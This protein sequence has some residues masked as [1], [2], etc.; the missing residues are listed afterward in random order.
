M[1][2]AQRIAVSSFGVD[3]R[4]RHLAKPSEVGGATTQH[5]HP[6]TL[7]VGSIQVG[8]RYQRGR[9]LEQLAN[10]TKDDASKVYGENCWRS[11]SERCAYTD[12]FY[13]SKG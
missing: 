7:A 4:L 8:L 1:L 2:K 9:T 6:G 3:K 13:C 5:A 10:G 11:R 12:G